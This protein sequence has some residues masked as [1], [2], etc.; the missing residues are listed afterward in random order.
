MTAITLKTYQQAALDTLTAFARAAQTQGPA[1]AFGALVGRPYRADAFGP[2]VPC[3]CLRIPTGGGKTVM[4]AHA[5]A[6]LARAWC[7]V[8]APVAVWLV[9]SDAIRQQTLKAL[10][11]PGHPNRAALT[12]AYGEALQ[13]C[14]LDE[15]AQ[16]A[17]P[18]WRRTAIVL[19]TSRGR[20][21]ADFVAEL[22]DGRV[23]VLEYK[24]AHLAHT[25]YELEKR[26]VGQLWAKASQGQ[27]IFGWLTADTQQPI[28]EQLQKIF[29]ANVYQ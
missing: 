26:A 4:A 13:V 20:F 12:A 5:V 9:P 17:P 21:Y 22:T 3:V 15:V 27:A 10:Q 16:I 25:P 23:A 29:G 8:D 11:T 1:Q 2:D 19:F 14:V 6:L 28:Q 7:N 24:G 18:D